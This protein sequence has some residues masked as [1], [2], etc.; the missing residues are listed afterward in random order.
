MLILASMSPLGALFG[1]VVQ[2]TIDGAFKEAV[3]TIFQGLAVGT[4]I[5]VT[6]FEVKFLLYARVTFYYRCYFMSETTNIQ[7]F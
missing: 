5:Y 4:F 6:F 7:I 2:N 1:M 3:M